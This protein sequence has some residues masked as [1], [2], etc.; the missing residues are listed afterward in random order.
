MNREFKSL[1]YEY[2]SLIEH[3]QSDGKIKSDRTRSD[4]TKMRTIC[5]SSHV[6]T[7]WLQGGIYFGAGIN[8]CVERLIAWWRDVGVNQET[9]DIIE[10]DFMTASNETAEIR[11]RR[12]GGEKIN[13][14]ALTKGV[15]KDMPEA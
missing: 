6:G 15:V 2:A 12:L 10:M 8:H 11:Q 3:R 4:L 5:A 1:L 14:V 13:L 9:I 7:C